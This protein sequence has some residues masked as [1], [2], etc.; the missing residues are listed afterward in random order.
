MDNP[1]GESGVT[2]QEHELCRLANP[3]FRACGTSTNAFIVDDPDRSIVIARIRTRSARG[4]LMVS[5][6]GN[7]LSSCCREVSAMEKYCRNDYI[8]LQTQGVP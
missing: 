3:T 6:P 4:V 1:P 8:V 5:S 2:H 7:Q